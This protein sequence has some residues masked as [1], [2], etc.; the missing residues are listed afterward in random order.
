MQLDRLLADAVG[1]PHGTS[2]NQINIRLTELLNERHGVGSL[3]VKAIEK[4]RERKSIPTA[5]LMKVAGLPTVREQAPL[6][7]AAYA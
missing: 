4:W 1:L 6:N 7:I 2:R 5:W 3:T